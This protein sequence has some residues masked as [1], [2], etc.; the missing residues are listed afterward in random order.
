MRPGVER[1]RRWEVGRQT[2]RD[3]LVDAL[4]AAQVPQPARPQVEQ[5]CAG[6]QV[7]TDERRGRLREQDLA[8]M[9][10]PP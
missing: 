3:K 5:A 4:R 7:V 10:N 8:A 2:R 1:D 6:R 9:A